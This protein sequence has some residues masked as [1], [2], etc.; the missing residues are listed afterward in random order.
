MTYEEGA[1]FPV[2]HYT[3]VQALYMRMGIPWPL[4]PEAT[5]FKKRGE[6]ILIWGGST[7]VGHH[8]IQL[9]ALSGL[10]VFATASPSAF[11]EVQALGASR[12][13]DYGDPEV[14][15]KIREAS[16]EEGIIY[17]LDAVSEK[18]TTEM[19][20]VRSFPCSVPC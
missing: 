4:T 9:A 1:S 2:P 11:E 16:G 17:A 15:S 12:A 10:Q 5:Q 13:F 7:A 3:A 14:A 18:G 6:K 19:T 8:A 20:V